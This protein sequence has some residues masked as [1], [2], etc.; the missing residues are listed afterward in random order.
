[1][2]RLANGSVYIV[3]SPVFIE[4]FL[5]L[6]AGAMF[7]SGWVHFQHSP[8]KYFASIALGLGGLLAV[9][10][11]L[12]Q[13]K[14]TYLFDPSVKRLTWT[15]RGLFKSSAGSM[16]F[17][18]ISD[19]RIETLSDNDGVT[20][21]AALVTPAGSLPL[22]NAYVG[23]QKKV[24]EFATSIIALIGRDPTQPINVVDQSGRT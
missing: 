1:M 22:S 7:A 10:G 8:P 21:R 12:A 23:N 5:I 20:Y 16:P 19:V 3:N 24:A 4:I 15:R 14:R 6:F 18:D 11:M 9:A 17:S 2:R 13:Q